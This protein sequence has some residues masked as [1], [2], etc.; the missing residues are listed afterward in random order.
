MNGDDEYYRVI[1]SLRNKVPLF[2][3]YLIGVVMVCASHLVVGIIL[4]IIGFAVACI[5]VLFLRLDLF[6][7]IGLFCI[8]FLL[9]L[10][11]LLPHFDWLIEGGLMGCLSLIALSK[12]IKPLL[13]VPRD[14][15]SSGFENGA[16][17]FADRCQ[18]CNA[19]LPKEKMYKSFRLEHPRKN[20]CDEC[21]HMK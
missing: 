6:A 16:G 3:L 14:Q 21:S 11:F 15:C 8:A 12:T 7:S 17:R 13:P 1:K 2:V 10:L 5:A 18:S 20:L 4:A 9:F 19:L